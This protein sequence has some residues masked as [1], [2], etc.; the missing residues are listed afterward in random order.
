VEIWKFLASER[1]ITRIGKKEDR[2]MTT[3]A[4]TNIHFN[5]KD[6]IIIRTSGNN[7]FNP[8][9]FQLDPVG[10]ITACWEGFLP[11]YLLENDLLFMDSLEIN[12]TPYEAYSHGS[13]IRTPAPEIDGCTARVLYEEKYYAFEYHYENLRMLINFTGG[14]V[15]GV[16]LIGNPEKEENHIPWIYRRVYELIFENGKLISS[17]DASE[18]MAEIRHKRAERLS[19]INASAE[20]E[21]LSDLANFYKSQ[22]FTNLNQLL[23][24]TSTWLRQCFSMEYHILL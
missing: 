3:Q 4:S 17:I 14:L 8:R 11:H 15:I 22:Y 1:P 20:L 21:D 24:D 12:L 5:N 6:F 9:E 19:K 16:D 13:V 18:S 2:E 7:L 10:R 23:H